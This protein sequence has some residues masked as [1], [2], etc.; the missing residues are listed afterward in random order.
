VFADAAHQVMLINRIRCPGSEHGLRLL[1]RDVAKIIARMVWRSRK[2]KSVWG[3]AMND[4]VA[5]Y[6]VS[7]LVS[8]SMRPRKVF[9]QMTSILDRRLPFKGL[10][11]LASQ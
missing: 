9:V 3:R 10:E 2:K 1:P 8:R 5:R 4:V 7:E 6:G 11:W